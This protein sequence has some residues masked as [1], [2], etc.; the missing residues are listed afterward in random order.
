MATKLA[1]TSG[2]KGLEIQASDQLSHEDYRKFVPEFERLLKEKGKIR[3]LFEMVNF[4]G[5]EFAALWDDVGFDVKHFS[6][7]ERLALVGDKAVGEKYEC[8][9][10]PLHHCEDSLFRPYG[11]G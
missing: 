6:H 3:L 9:L 1:E 4:H 2:G 5:R 8:I 7:I 10:P 11:N